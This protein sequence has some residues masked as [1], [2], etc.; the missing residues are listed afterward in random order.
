MRFVH[1]NDTIL[2]WIAIKEIKGAGP[3]TIGEWREKYGSPEAILREE[4]NKRQIVL[5][6]ARAEQIVREVEALGGY[7][8]STDCPQYPKLLSRIPDAPPVIFVKGKLP[9]NIDSS[10][11]VV[12]TRTCT[13][14]ASAMAAKVAHKLAELGR[15]V[16]SGLALGIDAAAHSA[17]LGRGVP[18][19]SVLAHGLDRI[20]P[21]ANIKLSE[22]ILEKGGALISEHPPGTQVKPW[23]FAS[24]NR[25]LVGLCSATVVIQSRKKGGSMLSADLALGYNRD[26]YAMYPLNSKEKAWEGNRHLFATTVAEKIIDIDSWGEKLGSCSAQSKVAVEQVQLNEKMPQRCRCVYDLIIERSVATPLMLSQELGE[27]LRTIRTR[28]FVLEILG[29][30]RRAPGDRY[31]PI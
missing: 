2:N 20:H 22:R 1:M 9:P 23:M 29:W 19:I 24:R 27:T 11:A 6:R 18:T 30:I 4:A 28:L 3:K 7:I 17:S 5:Y 26:T 21:M 8:I 12:G 10:V 15:P 25:I 16:V 31:V 14:E 13:K